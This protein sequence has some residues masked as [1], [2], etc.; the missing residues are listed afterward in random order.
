MPTYSLKRYQAQT[1]EAIESFFRR[2][3]AGE[4]LAAWAEAM[5]AQGRSTAYDASTL[6]DVPAVCVRIPTGGG[7]TTMAAHAVARVGRAFSGTDAPVVLWLTPSDAI[8]SQTL[9]ALRVPG[10]ACQAGLAE[11]FGDRV[12]VCALDELATVGPQ[13]LG[14]SAVIVV[15][16]I[17]SFN[18]K[19]TSQRNV[20]AFDEALAP[21]FQALTPQQAARLERVAQAD[22]ERQPYLGGGDVGRVKCSLANWLALHQ[23][24]VVVD[25]AHNNRT[26]Q[27]FATL[28][29]LAPAAVIEMTATPM[30]SSN[31]LFHVGAQALQREEMIK[32]PIVLMEHQHD[33]QGAVRDAILTRRRLEALA[34]QEDDYL[35]PVLLFQAQP[36]G[37]EVT[38]EALLAHL[39]SPDGENLPRAEI[40]VATGDQKE[41]DGVS[42]SALTCPVRYVVTV[43]ALK[44][45]W[46]CPFAYVLCSLQNAS[47]AKDVEQLLGRVLRMP[48]ARARRVPELNRAYAHIVSDGFARVADNLTDR[49]VNNMGFEAYEAALAVVAPV[50][51]ALPGLPAGQGALFAPRAPDAII[52]L[53]AMPKALLPAELADCLE[54]RATSSGATA[55]VRGELTPAVEDFLLQGCTPKQQAVVAQAIERERLRQSAALAP[56]LRGVPFAPLPQLCLDFDGER[57]ALDRRLCAELG[58]F[59]LFA[60]EARLS[61]RLRD[62][63]RVIEI[64]VDLGRVRWEVREAEQLA[65]NGVPSRLSEQDLIR[66]LDRECRQPDISQATLLRWLQTVLRRLMEN[67][68]LTLTALLRDRFALAEAV[69]AE[70][71]RLRELAVATGFQRALPGLGSAPPATTG[72]RH[73]FSFHPD[74]YPG[75]P[76]F[77]QGRYR[78]Q[79]HYYGAST[80]HDLRER[81]DAGKPAEEF[82]CAQA[83]DLEQRVKHWV[84]NVERD[85]RFSFWL[86][87]S[88][89]YFYPDFVAELNDGRVL[90]VEYKGK[91]LLGSFDTREKDL[92]GRQWAASSGGR[93][94]FLMAVEPGSDRLG[95]TL[96]DQIAD[97]IEGKSVP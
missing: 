57:V 96:A 16:T 87:T 94:L 26:H 24:L 14:A 30:P 21:H 12:R 46:D 81:T 61:F 84:R 52:S 23:P 77:Y 72:Y 67:P 69:R 92:I 25:E 29:R 66:W 40:A 42:I 9:A 97:T 59:D 10:N 54:L 83:I 68:A 28:K 19:D 60:N 7:K 35:R 33:W 43:E 13:E 2:A 45:G 8:R 76:P 27:A 89:D 1:L 55:I 41:L 93:C 86:P 95:R 65:L 3:Q 5:A 53:P 18:V 39:T 36:K 91:H 51:E 6:G 56:A 22:V 58:Q 82:L 32:L 70:L 64:D 80:I 62:Q 47:S 71:Q 17:Q 31:V 63:G 38:V 73:H 11:Q 49:L 75:R 44:E 50:Q 74:R 37:G 4:H 78:F 20:Y 15:A 79:K 34:A 88:S 85:E 48:Y 90:A